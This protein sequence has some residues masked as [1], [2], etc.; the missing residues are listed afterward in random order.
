VLLVGG[1]TLLPGFFSWFE[2]RFERRRVRAWQ[3]FEAVAYGA[4]NHVLVTVEIQG[5]PGFQGVRIFRETYKPRACEIVVGDPAFDDTFFIEGPMRLVSTLLDAGTRL[6]LTSINKKSRLEISGGKI[7]T[8]LGEWQVA[9]M[10]PLLVDLGR[11]LVQPLDVAD[12]VRRMA[13][14]AG[15][16]PATGVRLQN[17]LLL[18]R[19]FPGDPVTIE[20]LRRALLDESPQI[21]LRAA[22]EGGDTLL[23]LAENSIGIPGAPR[24][25]RPWTGSCRSTACRPSSPPPCAGAR[26]RRPA[27]A[28]M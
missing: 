18:V 25:S 19:E 28:S 12:V 22:K 2:D 27:P 16:D 24:P 8:E 26:S 13:A 3:P 4:A 7:L 14:N 5:P 15:D 11:R 9:D 17:L 20:A 21:Q 23:K 10:L 1:S 6:L